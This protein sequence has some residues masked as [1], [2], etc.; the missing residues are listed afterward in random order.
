[1]WTLMPMFCFNFNFIFN[2]FS[3]TSF[4]IYIFLLNN[5][6][7]Y[8]FCCCVDDCNVD[9]HANILFELYFILFFVLF[10]FVLFHT[11][12]VYCCKVNAHAKIFPTF[13]SVPC[14]QLQC[15]HSCHY[16]C[17]PPNGVVRNVNHLSSLCWD[18]YVKNVRSRSYLRGSVASGVAVCTHSGAAVCTVHMYCTVHC[19]VISWSARALANV[20]SLNRVAVSQPIRNQQ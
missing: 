5:F 6:I 15:W 14:P 2:S 10:C 17:S 13:L 20:P 8:Y 7:L 3:V 11:H 16:I 4:S 19:T 12:S 1:M 18:L 9:T